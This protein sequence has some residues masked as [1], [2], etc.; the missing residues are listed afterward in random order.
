MTSERKIQ[1]RELIDFVKQFMLVNE[2]QTC[3][4]N[5]L[6]PDMQNKGPFNN[7]K[8]L[9]CFLRKIK[10]D[11]NLDQINIIEFYEDKAWKWRFKLY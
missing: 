8:Q 6:F 11:G 4:V 7:P 9:R 3:G 10:S 5:R 1:I 2:I